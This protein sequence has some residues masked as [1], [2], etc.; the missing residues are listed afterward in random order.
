MENTDK[1]HHWQV[2]EFVQYLSKSLD[3]ACFADVRYE[4]YSDA[5]ICVSEPAHFFLP[6]RISVQILCLHI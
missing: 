1:V 2:G 5:A 3:W 4:A 6:K